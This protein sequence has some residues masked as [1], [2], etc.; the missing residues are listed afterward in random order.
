MTLQKRLATAIATGALLANS[1]LPVLASDTTLVINGNAQGSDNT[2]KV[3]VSKSNTVVQENKANVE[4]KFNIDSS[5]GD[6][7]A[8]GNNGGEIK[9][10]SGDSTVT[11]KA[12][13]QL[14]SNSYE[15]DCC[16][17]AGDTEIIIKDNAQGSDN[18]VKYDV[19]NDS[20]VFQTNDADVENKFYIDSTTDYNTANGNNGDG[21]IYVISGDST[22]VAKANTTANANVA[23]KGGNGAGSEGSVWLGVMDNGQYSDNEIDLDV[24][25]DDTLVQENEADVENK[26]DVDSSTGDNEADKNNGA[27][28]IRVQSG[29]S[30]VT[31]KADNTVNFNYM[32]DDC[33]CW[34]LGDVFAK[35]NGNAQ[36]SDNEIEA[37]FSIDEGKDEGSYQ[38]NDADIENKFDEIDSDTGY[39][40]SSKNNQGSDGD[41]IVVSGNSDVHAHATNEGNVNT[42]GGD[43]GI[44]WDWDTDEAWNAWMV[45]MGWYQAHN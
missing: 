24:E 41:P 12:D 40:G 45:F 33:G 21:D 25:I 11:A 43:M 17:D 35:V 37:E 27:G 16:E 3:D 18:K 8:D 1:V 30:D 28:Y 31:V 20:D 9:V 14:N 2:V 7:E 26:F 6:N 34:G 38:Y 36:Y 5:T 32:E 42:I 15:S 4:N 22:V 44:D 29:D 23:K 39:N 19:D 10:K 13:N